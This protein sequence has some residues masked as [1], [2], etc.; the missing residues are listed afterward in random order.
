MPRWKILKTPSI[1]TAGSLEKE[2]KVYGPTDV[3]EQ[4]D[5]YP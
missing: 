4:W 1:W 2:I 5:L 3:K